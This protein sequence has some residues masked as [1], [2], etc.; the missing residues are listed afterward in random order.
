MTSELEGGGRRS[1]GSFCGCGC[2][3]CGVD[4]EE[5][6]AQLHTAQ[7]GDELLLMTVHVVQTQ[8]DMCVF[9]YSNSVAK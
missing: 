9:V 2:G 1:G 7:A 4:T 5:L 3:G 8:E 6:R